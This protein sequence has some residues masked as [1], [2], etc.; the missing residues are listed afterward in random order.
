LPLIAK[1]DLLILSLNKHA[2]KHTFLSLADL[3]PGQWAIV[4]RFVQASADYLRL[5]ELGMI[6]GA[7]IQLVRRAPNGGPLQFKLG[8]SCFALRLQDALCL[9][10]STI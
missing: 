3:K 4:D 7:L 6:S 1:K 2:M 10:V 5:E 9:K 8:Q